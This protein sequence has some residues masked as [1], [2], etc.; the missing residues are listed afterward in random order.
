LT[1]GLWLDWERL[2]VKDMFRTFNSFLSARTAN[3]RQELCD[4]S[5]D[6]SG[7]NSELNPK[8]FYRERL[9]RR[10]PYHH[11]KIQHDGEPTNRRRFR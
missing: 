3:N 11:Q 4:A 7:P 5:L 10:R 9:Q 6:Q 1:W 8:R 2:R